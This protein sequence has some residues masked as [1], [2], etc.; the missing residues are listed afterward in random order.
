MSTVKVALGWSVMQAVND[1]FVPP[2]ARMI[3]VGYGYWS[4]DHRYGYSGFDGYPTFYGENTEFRASSRLWLGKAVKWLTGKE[5][6]ANILI[7]QEGTGAQDTPSGYEWG[8]EFQLGLDALGHTY[9]LTNSLVDWGAE[10]PLDYDLM[11]CHTLD[12]AHTYHGLSLA[13]EK[14]DY[15]LA[16]GGHLMTD[17]GVFDWARYGFAGSQ[18]HDNHGAA[19]GAPDWKYQRPFYCSPLGADLFA[20]VYYTTAKVVAATN[21]IGGSATI[22][23]C[24]KHADNGVLGLWET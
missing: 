11:L 3:G 1:E 13:T 20:L 6:G 4:A 14:L 17:F 12:N 5:T 16:N 2:P 22:Y 19:Y 15:F 18:W 10:E 9:T 21:T 8:N 7:V 24:T 23:D